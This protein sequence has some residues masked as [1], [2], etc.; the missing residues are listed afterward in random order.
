MRGRVLE[1]L[2]RRHGNFVWDGVLRGSAV[3][4]LVGIGVMRLGSPWVAGLAA[5]TVVT[6]WV[7]GPL[8]LFMPATYESILM[9]IGRVYPPWLVA[10]LGILGILYVEYLNFHLYGKVLHLP[11]LSPARESGAVRVTLRLFQRAPF[12]TVWLGSWSLVPLWTVRIVARLADYPVWRYLLA[13]LLGR[14]PR[15][16]FFAALGL[17]WHVSARVLSA[18][19]VGMILLYLAIWAVKRFRGSNA[20]GA[21]P[22]PQGT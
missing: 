18:I 5:F 14:G 21:A 16:W 1:T 3:L 19:T 9:L 4:A 2:R 7:N 6:I 17:Y 11:A 8:G 12:F 13:L 10:L 22:S 20:G 15:L